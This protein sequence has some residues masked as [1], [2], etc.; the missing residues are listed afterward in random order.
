[1]QY[2][3]EDVR[4]RIVNAAKTEFLR[5]GYS[6]ASMLQISTCAKVP[7]GNLYRYFSS[8]ASLFDAIVGTARER[9]LEAVKAS[10]GE[11]R[12]TPITEEAFKNKVNEVSINF[13]SI[14]RDYQ[15]ETIL[16]LQKSGGSSY[17]GF[18]DEVIA[19]V[20]ELL[21]DRVRKASGTPDEFLF[22]LIADNVTRGAFRILIERPFDEQMEELVKLLTF[23]F[24]NIDDRL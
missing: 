7:I 19:C 16:L 8:K 2:Q 4:K 15:K 18:I 3:K 5:V 17:D 20:K 23:Y 6:R 10:L 13:L 9:I 21:N 14:A 24:A 1:M 22:D 12:A 11:R